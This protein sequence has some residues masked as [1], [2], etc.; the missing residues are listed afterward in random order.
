MTGIPSSKAGDPGTSA[1]GLRYPLRADAVRGLK[2]AALRLELR[3]T[4]LSGGSTVDGD[5]HLLPAVI[6]GVF[7]HF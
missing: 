3:A 5:T 2:S 6:A 1:V 7:F 4:I